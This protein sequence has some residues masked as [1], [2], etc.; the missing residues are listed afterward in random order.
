[1]FARRL[2]IGLVIFLA[3]V[4]ASAQDDAGPAA[5]IDSELSRIED[6]GADLRIELALSRP[7]AWR[8]HTLDAPRR[9]VVDLD[10]VEL[11]QSELAGVVASDCVSDLRT[12]PRAGGWQRIVLTLTMPLR[13]ETAGLTGAGANAALKL[14]LA[15][16]SDEEFSR[17][18]ARNAASAPVVAPAGPRVLRFL[19]SISPDTDR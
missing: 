12:M 11:S 7:V 4:P 8:V 13:I 5:R 19:S 16:T 14:Q 17:T 6:F 15:P 2:A 1:M 18:V 10:G 3:A 9:L